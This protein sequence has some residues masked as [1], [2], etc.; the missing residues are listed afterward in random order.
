MI[1]IETYIHGQGIGCVSGFVNREDLR[2]TAMTWLERS[3]HGYIPVN[4][5][6][7]QICEKL[8]DSGPCIGSRTHR[9][10][11]RAFAYQIQRRGFRTYGY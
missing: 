2:Q 6:I 9:R 8:A 3:D 5:T 11:S 7:E 1:Y 10:V 4:S